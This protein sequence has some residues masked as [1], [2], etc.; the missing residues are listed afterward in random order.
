M[1]KEVKDFGAG[2]FPLVVNMLQNLD[3]REIFFCQRYETSCAF[4]FCISSWFFPS[5]FH[6]WYFLLHKYNFCLVIL[7][8]VC[9]AESK[10]YCLRVNLLETMLYWCKLKRK[11]CICIL[12]SLFSGNMDEV[13]ISIPRWKSLKKLFCI[14]A[15]RIFFL[16]FPIL[17]ACPLYLFLFI[18]VFFH[19]IFPNYCIMVISDVV[20]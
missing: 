6:T 10:D 16:N 3:K 8:G 13:W 7:S 20:N 17:L 5:L 11:K 1:G 9:R 12:C 15:N 2:L 19:K 14:D 4:I 18:M